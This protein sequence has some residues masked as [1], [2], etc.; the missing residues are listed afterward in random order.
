L[1]GAEK[2]KLIGAEILI[3]P[4]ITS[5]CLFDFSEE[6][7]FPLP[8]I[9]L[10][11]SVM[12]YLKRKHVTKFGLLATDGTLKTGIFNR[13]A[14]K[15]GLELISPAPKSQ[16]VVMDV[17]YNEIKK[18]D[19]G[20]KNKLLKISEDLVS[21]GAEAVILG[22]TELSLIELDEDFFIDPLK[23]VAKI[24]VKQCNDLPINNSTT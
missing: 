20:G 6:N 23:I 21:R 19:L 22:C 7:P 8:Y 3:I 4:C 18:G 16:E 10:P 1:Q 11:D 14:E 15:Y 12:A 2:L 5:H 17:I 24:A 13:Y 9:S